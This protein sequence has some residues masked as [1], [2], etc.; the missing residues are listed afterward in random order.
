MLTDRP[1][2]CSHKMKE[3]VEEGSSILFGGRRDSKRCMEIDVLPRIILGRGKSYVI[4][5][6]LR[7]NT[8]KKASGE[9]IRMTSAIGRTDFW[10]VTLQIVAPALFL[11]R[12][13]RMRR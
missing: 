11:P 7:N 8:S 6:Q 5:R 12:R 13:L 3:A 9:H 10:L 4:W 2:D 1:H